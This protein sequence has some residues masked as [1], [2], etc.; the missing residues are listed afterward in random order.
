DPSLK[1]LLI[2]K[3]GNTNFVISDFIREE[4][5][6][7]LINLI[8]VKELK[9][10]YLINLENCQ[11]HSYNLFQKLGEKDVDFSVEVLKKIDEL[12]IG[13]SNLGYMVLH[14]ISEFRDKKEI[15]K[16]FIR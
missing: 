2:Q 1:E 8:G 12:R 10:W 5:V 9:F 11:N 13:H 6:P 16:K 3:A 15:Y 14:S 4:E 7:K